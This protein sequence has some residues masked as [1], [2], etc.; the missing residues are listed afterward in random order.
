MAR[1]KRTKVQGRNYKLSGKD[2]KAPGFPVDGRRLP[3]AI[4]MD[5]RRNG[6]KAGLAGVF[7]DLESV[8]F[9]RKRITDWCDGV[10]A[11]INQ[12]FREPFTNIDELHENAERRREAAERQVGDIDEMLAEAKSRRAEWDGVTGPSR[13]AMFFVL[14]VVFLAQ[15]PAD[16]LAADILP[17]SPLMKMLVAVMAGG[18]T[19]YAAHYAGELVV[20]FKEAWANRHEDRGEAVQQGGMLAAV[21]LGPIAMIVAL[22]AWRGATLDAF[23]AATGVTESGAG[24]WAFAL[25]AVVAFIIGVVASIRFQPVAGKYQVDAEIKGLESAAEPLEQEKDLCVQTMGLADKRRG[26]L[27]EDMASQLARVASTRDQALDKLEIR[28]RETMLKATIAQK[29]QEAKKRGKAELRVLPLKHDDI[30]DT[31]FGEA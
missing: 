5:V 8:E 6:K 11:K 3:P 26:N 7:G 2:M 19:A 29:K 10:M 22:T 28:F 24:N 16:K 31:K 30:D 23:D 25:F 15:M 1:K 12:N 9:A 17:L 27:E 14:A 4:A 18:I 13:L 20:K 21:V